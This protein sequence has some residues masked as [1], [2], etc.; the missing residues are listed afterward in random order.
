MALFINTFQQKI[1]AINSDI[2]PVL[3]VIEKMIELEELCIRLLTSHS[4]LKK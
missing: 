3:N 4:K 1:S 2:N